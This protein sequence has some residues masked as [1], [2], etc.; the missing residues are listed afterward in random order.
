[1]A[2]EL[3]TTKDLERSQRAA[4]DARKDMQ[5]ALQ[6]WSRDH[7]KTR[8]VYRNKVKERLKMM[9]KEI[10]LSVRCIVKRIDQEM[11][12]RGRKVRYIFI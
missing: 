6:R 7:E 9:E 12:S 2:I 8:E 10:E 4:A 3:A 5:V 1:M 11:A